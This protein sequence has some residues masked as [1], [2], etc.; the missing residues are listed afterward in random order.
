MGNF[1]I[2]SKALRQ[3]I[4]S[5][6]LI[7]L[8]TKSSHNFPIPQQPLD[9]RIVEEAHNQ[10]DGHRQESEPH[11]LKRHILLHLH[12]IPTE[13]A[14]LLPKY[15]NGLMFFLY[16]PDHRIQHFGLILPGHTLQI[17]QLNHFL[18]YLESLIKLHVEE[19]LFALILN[20]KGVFGVHGR[21]AVDL[22]GGLFVVM[23]EEHRTVVQEHLQGEVAVGCA[24]TDVERGGFA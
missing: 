3:Y 5:D 17:G 20:T 24:G 22:F 8:S 16:D 6:A 9:N 18:V 4:I 11:G 10:N 1:D 7:H 2:I 19:I 15:L 21:I 13:L 23:V 12:H 14:L